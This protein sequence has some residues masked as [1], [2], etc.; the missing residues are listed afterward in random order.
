MI[1]PDASSN[2]KFHRE[3]PGP[4]RYSKSKTEQCSLSKHNNTKSKNQLHS[5][6]AT[7]NEISCKA[8]TEN[9]RP[10]STPFRLSLMQES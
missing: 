1:S 9:M 3:Q 4:K 2:H 7:E 5:K 8:L 10:K 6:H